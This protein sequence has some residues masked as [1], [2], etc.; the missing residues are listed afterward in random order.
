MEEQDQQE[1]QQQ[2]VVEGQEEVGVTCNVHPGEQ[3][4]RLV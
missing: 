4:S 3:S 2:E 1:D